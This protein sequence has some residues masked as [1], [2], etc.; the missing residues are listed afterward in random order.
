MRHSTSTVA[1]MAW[2][3]ERVNEYILCVLRRCERGR[4]LCIL[5]MVKSISK[6]IN[7][8]PIVNHV[9]SYEM[10]SVTNAFADDGTEA[11]KDSLRS[12]ILA[13]GAGVD[14]RWLTRLRR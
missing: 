10:D 7:I 4:E 9:A 6:P 5:N 14:A 11:A 13:A 8:F 3:L 2:I 1:M 12:I